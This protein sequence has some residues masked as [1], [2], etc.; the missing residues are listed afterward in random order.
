MD[1][2]EAMIAE[3]V[4]AGF[5]KIHLDTSMGC[6]GEP[7]ALPDEIVAERAS[8]LALRAEAV[9]TER[10]LPPPLYVIGTEVPVPGGASHAID[11]VEVTAPAAAERTLAVHRAAFAKRGIGQ[12]LDRIIA[13][14]VQPG[15]EF[16]HE[17][18]IAF[19]PKEARGL[20][21]VLERERGLVF[22]AHSTDYQTTEALR[23]LVSQGFAVLKVGPAL[24]FALRET[25]YGLDCIAT[26]LVSGWRD[27]T[28]GA[29]ME[30]LMLAE[31]RFWAPYYTGR[32]DARRILRHY[33]YSD[34]IRYYWPHPEALA[35]AG[36]LIQALENRELPETLISQFLP[37]GYDG[38][39]K[40][41]VARRPWS[42]LRHALGMELDRYREA[43]GR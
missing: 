28:L 14:V 31:P 15:V 20:S 10:G 5:A 38:V 16:D 32:D 17:R 3:Y 34:R 29:T 11:R 35:A 39:R 24:T 37:R 8:R 22:E 9:A 30:R 26:E 40:Q 4:A 33:S 19:Q 25:L 2:A 27:H 6:H 13:V 36:S 1:K 7:A 12:A 43:T 41:Q 23:A 42:L 21:A 18:V